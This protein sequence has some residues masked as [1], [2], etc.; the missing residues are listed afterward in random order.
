ML[1]RSSLFSGRT[2]AGVEQLENCSP[3]ENPSGT[4]PSAC[5]GEEEGIRRPKKIKKEA[6][7]RV[8]G[9]SV[10]GVLGEA[11]PPTPLPRGS[12]EDTGDATWRKKKK[13]FKKMLDQGE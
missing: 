10:H 5:I 7:G 6:A 2:L 13:S 1:E 3:S 8:G 4:A 11:P 9:D 12:S